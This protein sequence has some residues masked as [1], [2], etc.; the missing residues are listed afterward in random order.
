MI[1]HY[2]FT[3]R[4]RGKVWAKNKANGEKGAAFGFSPPL[5]A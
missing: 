2:Y 4:R 1:G 5:T 3:T